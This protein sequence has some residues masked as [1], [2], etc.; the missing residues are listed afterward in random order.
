RFR[1]RS[2]TAEHERLT[3]AALTRAGNAERGRKEVFDTARSQRLKCH[4]LGDQGGRIGPELTGV[5]SRYSTIHL[6]QSILEPSGTIAPSS[7][8]V[9][10]ALKDGRVFS[11]VRVAETADTLTLADSKGEKQVLEKSRIEE[12]RTQPVSTMPDG[13]EKPLTTDEFVDLI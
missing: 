1:R 9:V 11:G 6:I 5:S 7:E 2:T 10:V 3:Q 8:T 13:L 4:R 12:R